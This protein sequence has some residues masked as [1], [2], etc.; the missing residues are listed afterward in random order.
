MPEAVNPRCQRP[1]R[2]TPYALRP[3]PRHTP[4]Y[5]TFFGT[6]MCDWGVMEEVF[7]FDTKVDAILVLPLTLATA[8][9]SDHLP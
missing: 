3:T 2:P 9:S 1:P 5:A 4:R 7:P 8:P 6:N